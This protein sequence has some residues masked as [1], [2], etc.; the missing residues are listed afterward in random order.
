MF[1]LKY[2]SDAELFISNTSK[3][4]SNFPSLKWL[5]VFGPHNKVT[6]IAV[7]IIKIVKINGL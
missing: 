5:S 6:L 1:K 7:I 4:Y 3:N 2:R